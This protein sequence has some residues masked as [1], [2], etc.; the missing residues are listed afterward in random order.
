MSQAPGPPPEPRRALVNAVAAFLAVAAAGAAFINLV[1]NRRLDNRRQAA[2]A[3]G[4]ERAQKLENELAGSMAALQV[5]AA[6]LRQAGKVKDFEALA[7]DVTRGRAAIGALLLAPGGVVSEA[8]PAEAAVERRGQD[9]LADKVMGPFAAAARETGRLQV[10]GPL[11][12]RKRGTVL[13]VFQ[14]VSVPE[15]DGRRFWGLVAATLEVRALVRAAGFE[16]LAELG[17]HH[18]LSMPGAGGRTVVLAR[19]TELE[20]KDPMEVPLRGLESAWVLALWPHAGWRSSSILGAEVVLV[21]VLGLALA[22]ATHRLSRE[23]EALRKEV[24]VRS[25]RLSD[26]HRQLEAEV[27]QRQQVEQRLLHHANFDTLT[28]LPNRAD[29]VERVSRTLDR[30]KHRP[31][32]LC[33]VLFVDVDHFKQVNDSLGPTLGDELLV[34]IARRVSHGLRPGDVVARVGGD[35]FAAL[36]FDVGGEDGAASVADRLLKDIQH[37]FDLSGEEVFASA[38]I[39]IALSGPGYERGEDLLRDSNIATHQAKMQGRGRQL[40][41]DGDMHLRA[42]RHLRLQTDLR[43]AIER[44][45]FQAHYQPIVSLGTG[46]IVGCE[47][48]VRW[49]HPT[50]GRVAPAEFLPLAES[51]GMVVWIDRWMLAEAARQ[52]RIWQSEFP[53]EPPLSISV[54]LSA[55]QLG[56]PHL[57]EHVAHTLETA[58]LP[59]SSLK[60]EV[61]ESAV[62]E[63]PDA[64]LDI[65]QG[66]RGMGLQLLIDDF[67]TGY[68]SLSYLQRFPFHMVKID[69]SFVKTMNVD[70]RNREI[71]RTILSLAANLGMQV[72]AEGIETAQQLAELRDAGTEYGQG[73]FFSKP[74][75]AEGMTSLLASRPSY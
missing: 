7:E 6:V 59:A 60:L 10:A 54:N 73:Y 41:F 56:Q 44:F 12:A 69:Q 18:R 23:P 27:Q 45:E 25:R 28:S 34:G 26:T 65:L 13:V 29:F 47:A 33:A 4:R 16:G 1:E 37:P 11:T 51:N 14:P 66:L 3:A 70:A 43:H 21:L 36:L 57:L 64:A 75:G 62:M 67:G 8:W 46:R 71:V 61:T 35:E 55:R 52:T 38:S 22:L 19:S 30:E 2:M 63:N 5:P 39:G 58:G 17:Y 40:V 15:R 72:I 32:S 24:A 49:V 31:G 9:L 50:R 68:S 42:V 74:L 20:A 48:L 53:A